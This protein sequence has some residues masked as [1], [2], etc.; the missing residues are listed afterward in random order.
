MRFSDN[1][2]GLTLTES[3]VVLAIVGIVMGSIWGVASAVHQRHQIKVATGQLQ[4]IVSNMRALYG[5]RQVIQGGLLNITADVVNLGV[6]PVD[7]LNAG[8]PQQ[9]W[10][11]ITVNSEGTCGGPYTRGSCDAGS[12]QVNFVNGAGVAVPCAAFVASVVGSFDDKGLIAIL[13]N[14]GGWQEAVGFAPLGIDA[15]C[16]TASF[17]FKL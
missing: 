15:T 4:T 2:K 1:R 5:N 17:A 7:M 14:T 12:F 10:G 11:T 6:I 9:P 13:T 3:A 8:V 16:V